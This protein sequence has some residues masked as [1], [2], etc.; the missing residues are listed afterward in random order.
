MPALI[1]RRALSEFLGG[2]MIEL[3]IR[4]VDPLRRPPAESLGN[5]L[6]MPMFVFTG[7]DKK[8][9]FHL[10]KFTDSEYEVPRGYFI[11]ERLTDLRDTEREL[12]RCRVQDVLEIG[13]YSLRC[14]RAQVGKG[15]AII[16]RPNRSLKHEIERSGFG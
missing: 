2:H 8:L 9:Q 13:E 15:T 3:Q 1:P 5:P 16:D 10:F 6:L 7:F 14:F 12:G 4:F 11:S